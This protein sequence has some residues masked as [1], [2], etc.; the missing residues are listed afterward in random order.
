MIF[1]LILITATGVQPFGS[2]TNL[3]DC[4]LA[5]REFQR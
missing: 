5:A 4:Q 2:Y 3:A 1:S